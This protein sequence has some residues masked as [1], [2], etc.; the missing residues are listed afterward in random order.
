MASDGL[1]MASEVGRS[2]EQV[3]TVRARAHEKQEGAHEM[4]VEDMFSRIC[5]RCSVK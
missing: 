5:S 3:E 4:G 2:I 1:L